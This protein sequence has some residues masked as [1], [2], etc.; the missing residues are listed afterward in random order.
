[1]EKR[2]RGR[3]QGLPILGVPLIISG[4]GKAMDFKFCMHIY[5]LNPNKSRLKL[6]GKVAVGVAR[7]SRKISGHPHTYRAHRSVIFAIAL[8][9]LVYNIVTGNQT[10]CDVIIMQ[11]SAV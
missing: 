1:M 9:F 11:G 4:T 2:K 3:I 5:R 10:L 8:S 6:S 7:D